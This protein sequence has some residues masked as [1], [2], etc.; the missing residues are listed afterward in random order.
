M[1]FLYFSFF[2][3]F[4]KKLRSLFVKPLNR[5]NILS[6]SLT[7]CRKRL[8]MREDKPCLF[9]PYAFALQKMIAPAIIALLVPVATGLILGV[10]GI[11]GMLA[12]SMVTGFL[13]AVF[14]SNSGGAWDNAKKHIEAGNFGGKGSDCHKAAV[15][16]DTVGDP[17]KDTSGPALN[18]LIKFLSIVSIIFAQ[19]IV[20]FSLM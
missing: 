8:E 11:M 18:I 2:Y 1:D 14:M 9:W 17:F 15:V 12:G 10:N 13:L 20:N 5:E 3:S 4:Q 7:E 16:G 6:R 19:V